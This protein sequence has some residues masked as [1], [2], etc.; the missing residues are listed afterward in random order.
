MD[1]LTKEQRRRNMQAIRNKNTRIEIKLAKGLYARGYRYRKNDKTV[2]GK[3]DISF[4][5]FKIAIFCDSEYFHGKNWEKE[6]ERI[7]TNRDFWFSK[8]ESNMQRDKYVND[9]LLKNGW[10]VLRFWGNEINKN[11]EICIQTIVKEIENKN[12]EIHRNKEKIK[13]P[14]RKGK[15]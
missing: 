4:K 9:E 6:K 15:G 14:A 2:L 8:I 3:P 11:L 13:H 5:K 12:G 7:K 10:K 1:V